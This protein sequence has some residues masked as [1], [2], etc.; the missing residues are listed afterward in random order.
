MT[1]A[2]ACRSIYYDFGFI[3]S[4]LAMTHAS[5]CPQINNN[6]NLHRQA[7]FDYF[8]WDKHCSSFAKTFPDCFG[9][10]GAF[11]ML[12]D[13]YGSLAKTDTPIPCL[14]HVIPGSPSL[15]GL[16]KDF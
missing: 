14:L 15:R 2:S 11:V 9:L 13:Y 10:P 6:L 1:H 8:Y 16:L 3:V 7:S 12:E 5:V 4:S